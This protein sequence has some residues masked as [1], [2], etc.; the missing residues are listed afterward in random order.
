MSLV[1]VAA[2]YLLYQEKYLAGALLMSFS[3]YTRTEGTF[4]TVYI[5]LYLLL[6]G[7]WKYIPLLGVGFLIYSFIGKFSG[8]DFLWFFSENPYKAESPYG[9]G[10][11]LDILQRYKVIW[12]TPQTILLII[13]LVSSQRGGALGR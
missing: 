13:S 6:I 3:I 10:G 12:G 2:I 9:H 7:K 8:H 4:L 1:L 11:W 5:L